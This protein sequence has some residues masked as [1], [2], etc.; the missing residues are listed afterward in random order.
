MVE[1]SI[2]T[3]QTRNSLIGLIQAKRLADASLERIKSGKRIGSPLDGVA[4][5]FDASGLSS[6]AVRLLTLKD[7][8][9]D[10]ATVT[11]GAVAAINTIINKVNEMKTQ[12]LAAKAGNVSTTVTG[13]VVTTSSANITAT[14]AGADDADSFNITH[15]GTTTTI[16]NNNGETFDSLVAQIDGISGLSAT[17]SDGN[18]IVITAIDGNDIVIANNVN[19]LAT[20]LGLAT[21]TNG[22]AASTTSLETSEAAFDTLRREI[23]TLVGQATFSGVNLL[24]VNPDSLTVGFNED[25]SSSLTISGIASDADSLGISA[26]NTTNEFST[27]AKINAVIDTLDTALVTLNQTKASLA[28]NDLILDTRLEFTESLIDLLNEGAE[29]LIGIDLNEESALL[30]ALQT[31]HDLTAAGIGISFDGGGVLTSLLAIK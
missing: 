19:A 12:A 27:V 29:K 26:V 24:T 20:D 14:L 13:S 23:N 10:A 2:I 7:R 5:F 9:T 17:V 30:L 11:G 25:G 15:D 21:S 8:I 6:R 1:F 22:S 4:A 16:T 28:A 3:A 31:R 18:A